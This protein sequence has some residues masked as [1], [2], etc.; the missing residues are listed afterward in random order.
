MSQPPVPVRCRERPQAGGLV[1]PFISYEHAGHA[2]FGAINPRRRSLALLRALCQICGQQLDERLCLTVRPMD[3]QAG[4]APEPGLHP[5]CLAYS[6]RACPMLSGAVAEYRT[7]AASVN[8]PA[9]KPC[10]DPACPCPR[11]L[12]DPHHE[13][14]SGRPA[15]AWDSWMIHRRHYR[16]KQNPQQPGQL[17]GIDLDVPVLRIRP[18]RR[19]PRHHLDEVHTRRMRALDL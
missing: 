8:H 2:V 17:L 4:A 16:V 18:L 3:F 19:S 9:G 6:A 5:E 13:I 14:R 12:P 15:D 1:V 7:T 10:S 11:M